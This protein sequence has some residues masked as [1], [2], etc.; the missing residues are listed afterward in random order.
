MKKHPM[1]PFVITLCAIIFWG[2]NFNVSKLLLSV[3]SPFNLV[4]IRFVCSFLCMIPIILLMETRQNI[5]D[6]VK[7]NKWIY[8]LLSLVGIIGYNSLL[9]EGIQNTS[10]INAALI[11]A[12]NPPVTMLFASFMLKEKI[13]ASQLMGALISLFSV[14]VVITRGS[15]EELIHLRFSLG[16]LVVMMA[17]VC[18]ALY[19]VLSKKYLKSNSSLITTTST[20]FISAVVLMLLGGKTQYQTLHL[21]IHQSL[22][23][24]FAL[25]HMIILGTV[26]AYLCWNYGISQLGSAKTAIFFNLIP[27]VTTVIAFFIGQPIELIQIVGGL[28]VIFGVLLSTN[29]ITIPLRRKSEPSYS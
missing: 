24:Y 27:V 4:T 25:L 29:M 1:I 26:C 11:M 22:N 12:T 17:N 28:S 10:A 15:W 23:I 3:L 14:G 9:F 2:A 18:W 19:N 6:N 13:S 5:I 8:I 16:D 20:M 21:L 7:E